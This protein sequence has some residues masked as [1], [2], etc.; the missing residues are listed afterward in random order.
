[1][2]A[3]DA[4]APEHGDVVAGRRSVLEIL[5]ARGAVDRV[6]IA[7]GVGASPI[8]RDI[9]REA[10]AAAV[11]VKVVPRAQIDRLAGDVNHQGVAAVAGRYRYAPL[12]AVLARK[13]SSLLLLD[14][15]MDPHNVGSL[16][17]SAEV[18]GFDGVVVRARRAAG[19][20]AA[21]RRVAAGAAETVPVSRV[22][23]VVDAIR[24][25]QDAGLWVVGLDERA[26]R[27][28]WT[29]DALEPPVGI[30]VG[31]EDKG[32][33]TAVARACDELVAIPR[34]GRIESLNAAV[35]G[36]V[37]MFEVARR[38]ADN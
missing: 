38:R 8:V 23:N 29:T 30:V 31:A 12:D 5:R 13:P 32:L 3:R 21:A 11:P 26:A 19:V 28:L 24:R 35:A 14:G 22:G 9:R 34:A 2:S 17:R 27:D 25:S 10:N 1:M 7:D 37:A 36:A 4:P 18:A 6:L 15:V 16:L 20:T 33:S